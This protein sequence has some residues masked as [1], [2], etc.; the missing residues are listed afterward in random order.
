MTPVLII[1]K[2]GSIILAKCGTQC[3]LSAALYAVRDHNLFSK[4]HT[5]N[6]LR[7]PIL[8]NYSL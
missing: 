5:Q 3:P 2:L 8:Q 4:S 6:I 1:L 7:F